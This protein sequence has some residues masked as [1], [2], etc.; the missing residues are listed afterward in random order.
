MPITSRFISNHISTNMLSDY[1]D[2]YQDLGAERW[3]LSMRELGVPVIKRV[4]EKECDVLF[5]WRDPQGDDA[6]SSITTV[7]MDVN[8]VTDHHSLTPTSM[9]RQ[10]GTDIWFWQ[11][12][13]PSHW[14]G[15][16][17]FIPLSDVE[18]PQWNDEDDLRSQQRR[19]W[20]SIMPFAVPDSLNVWRGH[21]G[22]WGSRLSAL[23]LPDAPRQPAW[24]ARDSGADITSDAIAIRLWDSL[25]LNNHRQ[26]WVY[27]TQTQDL[28]AAEKALRP[29]VILLD[30]RFWSE[31]LPIF[32][33]LDYETQ[34]RRIPPAVYVLI[35]EIDGQHR[36]VELPCNTEFWQAVLTELI[37][38]LKADFSFTEEAEKTVV[39]GQSFGGLSAMYAGYNWP[40]RFGCVIAQSGSFWWPDVTLLQQNTDIIHGRSPGVRGWLTDQIEQHPTSTKLSVYLEA[41]TREGEMIDLAESMSQVLKAAGH[42]VYFHSFEGGHDRLCWRGS[43]LDALSLL[44]SEPSVTAN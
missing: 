30:G 32:S 25:I 3:W 29:L 43:L 23:H 33:A 6:I 10:Q 13:L 8:S 35:D 4:S 41:G 20:M 5:L 18:L 24:Y 12:R 34:Q 15:S 36:S 7:Y 11:V 27:E 26:V 39:A 37:P 14:R 9:K 19:W 40:D 1:V 2:H 28:T 22:H 44:L 16:Y 31:N 17:Q 42:Q 21:V 38:W